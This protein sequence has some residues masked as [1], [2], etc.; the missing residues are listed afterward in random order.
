[1]ILLLIFGIH[2]VFFLRFDK[3]IK[4]LFYAFYLVIS[5][6]FYTLLVSYL[7]QVFKY[8]PYVQSVR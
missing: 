8:S 3:L 7:Y 2:L 5:Y 6:P 4:W 1:M